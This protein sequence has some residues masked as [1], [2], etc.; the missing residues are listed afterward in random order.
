MAREPVVI[1]SPCFNENVTVIKF[2][3]ELEEVFAKSSLEFVVVVVDDC[4][5]DNTLLLLKGHNF[6]IPNAQ[7]KVI[8]LKY[9]LGHQGAIYQGI[10]Y[11]RTLGAEY[12][13][14]MDSDGEDD[15]TA[16]LEL[17]KYQYKEIDIVNLV[18]GK[19]REKLSFRIFYMIYKIIF[20]II[21]KKQMNFGNYCMINKKIIDATVETSF[22]HFAAHLSKQKA[23]A[24]KVVSDR[25]RRI[26]GKSKMNLDNLIHHA[27]KS[28]VEYAEELLMVFLK[29]FLIISITTVGLI[30]Y[31]L[32]QKLFTDRAILGWASTLTATFLNIGLICL[33]FF[34]MGILLLNI[35]AKKDV[36]HR[37]DVY[38]L[39]K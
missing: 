20:F 28:F 6:S 22:I 19:R 2:L 21:T 7:L 27:F 16:I 17:L 15:P 23:K 18:R 3:L 35:M 30:S 14:V 1:V 9:N 5:T 25:R 12:V 13:I 8:S 31:I 39:I 32:Y 37:E 10:S 36:K 24:I 34:V 4:S 38:V 29:L 11:A 33:G 26:D